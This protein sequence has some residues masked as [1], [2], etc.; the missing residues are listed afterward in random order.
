MVLDRYPDGIAGK[1]FFQKNAPDFVPDWVRTETVWSEDGGSQTRFFVCDDRET[2]LYLANLGTIP[3]HVGA[4]R[5]AALQ[6]PDWSILDLDAK[7]APFAAAVRVALALRRLTEQAGL[8]A[9]VKTSGASGLHVLIPLGAR[10]PHELSRRLAEVLAR[11]VAAELPAVASVARRPA[12]RPG[13]V[14]VDFLQN[15]YGKLLVAPYSARPLPGAPVSMPLS[16]DE[17]TPDLDPRDFTL[18]TAPRRLATWPGDPLRP[19]LTEAPDL[20]AALARLAAAME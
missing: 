13:K 6:H 5:F 20:L 10:V 16:W 15:G 1:S 11:L 7:D 12:D 3:L 14:Y 9:Y 18:A 2:L 8:P 19:V 17:L 4:A